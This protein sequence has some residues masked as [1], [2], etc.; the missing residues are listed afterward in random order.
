MA[1]AATDTVSAV[2]RPNRSPICPTMTPPSG[3]TTKPMAKMP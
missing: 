2:P 1:I 3:R